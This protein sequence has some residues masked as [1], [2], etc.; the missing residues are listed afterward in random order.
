MT[1]SES[2]TQFDGIEASNPTFRMS[3]AAGTVRTV[4]DVVGAV[5]D[6]CR[7]RLDA[8]GI[9]VSA[10]DPAAIASV[11]VDVPAS[12]FD[13]YE[14]EGGTIGV[15]LD[16][17]ADVLSVA[18]RGGR[19]GFLLDAA[20]RKLHVVIGDLEYTMALIDP[21]SI[22]SPPDL[23]AAEFGFTADA[24]LGTD[25]IDRFVRAADMVSD[26]V[27]MGV[28]DAEGAFYVEAEG[29]TDDV[30][31]V[32]PGEELVDLTPGEA[33]S[34]YSVDYLRELS[35]VIPSGSDV[36]L[37]LGDEAPLGIGYELG[38]GAGSV[39]GYLSPRIARS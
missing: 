3:A 27:G 34:L 13:V 36:R 16:R 12:A 39:E 23:S 7:L 8:D 6:E 21:E 29:D 18:D 22:R 10:V 38:D 24:V 9:H 19:V 11:S 30:S 17:L 26:H 4:V 25:D 37:R 31:L 1:T 14:G 28:D 15:D 20:T 2:D 33:H 32:L 35:R 5:V